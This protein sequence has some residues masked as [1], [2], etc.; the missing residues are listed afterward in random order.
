MAYGNKWTYSWLNGDGLTCTVDVQQDSYSSSVTSLVPAP[1][2]MEIEWGEGGGDDLTKPLH[3]SRATL[4]FIGDS[5]AEAML[6]EVFDSPDREYRVKFTVGGSLEWQGFLATDLRRYDPY[7]ESETVRLE[8][9]DGLA[10]LENEDAVGDDGDTAPDTLA[11]LLRKILR[12]VHNL[13]IYTS[14]D[15]HSKDP[16]IDSGE[17]P[18]D[19]YRT[20]KDAYKIF[21]ENDDFKEY[22]NRKSQLK[23]LLQRFGLRLRLDKG[24]WHLRQRDQI[25]D[26]TALKR[27]TLLTSESSFGTN[28]ST[29]DVSASLPP[30]SRSKRPVSGVQRLRSVKSSYK[31]EDLDELVFNGGFESSFNEWQTTGTVSRI[32]YSNASINETQTQ[33]DKY[34]VKMDNGSYTLPSGEDGS[35]I[36]QDL[37]VE[38]HDAGPGSALNVSWDILDTINT[39]GT[40]ETRIRLGN[41]YVQA[42][43]IEVAS[44]TNP[45]QDGNGQALGINTHAGATSAPGNALGTRIT[46]ALDQLEGMTGLDLHLVEGGPVH[47]LCQVV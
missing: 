43:R 8:A 41:C 39:A 20:P 5:N 9:I 6:D 1:D 38:L 17:C 45:A 26:G 21:D 31:Y 3:I 2:G 29:V 22:V 13:D 35:F 12:S 40:T 15:W 10:Y 47:D 32:Q 23:D 28:P 24:A 34:L 46:Y 16:T 25:G 27:W 37:P 11:V 36:E 44:D 30:G 18:L 7:Q 19:V 33:E 4:R 14:M 42:R